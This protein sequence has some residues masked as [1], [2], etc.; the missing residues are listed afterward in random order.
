MD[1]QRKRTRKH[2]LRCPDGYR[3]ALYCSAAHSSYVRQSVRRMMPLARHTPQPGPNNVHER[4]GCVKRR[5]RTVSPAALTSQRLLLFTD[6][7][8]LWRCPPR[9]RAGLAT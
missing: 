6:T 4:A 3:V 1:A 8:R 5:E 9:G 7:E 2:E